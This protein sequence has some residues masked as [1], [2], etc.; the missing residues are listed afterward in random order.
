[1]TQNTGILFIGHGS[2]LP[3]NKKV[4]TE[5]AEKYAQLHPD[6]H[7]DVGFMELVEPNIPTAFNTL[8]EKGVNRIIVNPIFLANGMHTRV[9]IPTILGLET[10]E[11]K[12]FQSHHVHHHHHDHDHD[13]E[14]EH[15]H[16]HHHHHHHHEAK[17]EPVDFD[18]E[19]VYLPPIGADDKIAE[20]ITDK[21]NQQLEHPD[22][23]PDNTGILLIGHGS[24]L[25][26]NN[27]V[28]EEIAQKYIDDNPDYNIEVGFMQLSTPTIPDAVAKLKQKG[29]ENI[30]ANPVFLAEG[31]HTKIDIPST[32]N[33]EVQPV[34]N[35]NPPNKAY[36]TVDFDG[37]IT[38]TTPLGA[39]DIIVDI[40]DERISKHM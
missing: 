33:L 31:I 40:I 22:K 8:K 25:P 5:V 23:N 21:I 11:M 29:V 30:I 24:T 35:Y 7:V 14:H 16:H 6:Y 15:A 17:S 18:G 1:M 28:V 34:E 10:E 3:Y 13:H 20:I 4:V 38:L 37:E 9:D 12:Q 36:D 32:L 26:Y 27:E 39:D 2:R 19:I